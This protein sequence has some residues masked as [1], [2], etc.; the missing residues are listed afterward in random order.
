M[1][2][3]SRKRTVVLDFRYRIAA[4]LI[5]IFDVKCTLLCS[6]RN[7]GVDTHGSTRRE[8]TCGQRDKEQHCQHREKRQRVGG[9][10][11]EEQTAHQMRKSKCTEQSNNDAS[12]S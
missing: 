12:Q 1:K 6:Q 9:L 5:Q 7:H 8:K 4:L 11:T 3:F 2:T 10:Y